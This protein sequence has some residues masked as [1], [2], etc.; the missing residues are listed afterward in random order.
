[1]SSTATTSIVWPK[2]QKDEVIRLIDL[3]LS[4]VD[5]KEPTAGPRLA[6]EVFAKNG[7]WYA[8]LGLFEGRGK[9]VRIMPLFFTDLLG[10]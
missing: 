1:M 2:R 7:K 5:S 4:L 8:S 3:Y 6:N 10:R 9:L